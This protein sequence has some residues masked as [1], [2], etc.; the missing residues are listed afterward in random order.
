MLVSET[1]KNNKIGA[2]V[3][4][5]LAIAPILD[6]YIL[7]EIGSI[8]IR[9]MDIPML[10][11]SGYIILRKRRIGLPNKDLFML[12]VIFMLLTLITYFAP[13]DGRNLFLGMKVIIV[14]SLYAFCVSYLWKVNQYEKFIEYATNIAI[15]ATILLIIQLIA[16]SLNF[17]NFYNGKLPILQLSK[18]DGWSGLI[19]PHTGDIRVHSFFQEPS[20]FGIYCLPVFAQALKNVRLRL[21]FFLF[22]GL[23]MTSSLLSILGGVC[24]FICVLLMYKKSHRKSYNKYLLKIF[25]IMCVVVVVLIT[26]YHT[27]NSVQ[28]IINYS[29]RR[30]SSISYDL[31]GDRMG[32]TKL[33]IIGYA[34]YYKTYPTFFKIFGVGASQYPLYLTHYGV[35]TYSSTLVTILLNYGLLGLC[36]FCIWLMKIFIRSDSERKCFALIFIIICIVDCFWFNWYFFYI[37]TWFLPF[38]YINKYKYK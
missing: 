29:S 13:V 19:D 21:S 12:L 34:R 35:K 20:Y 3:A 32:S 26:L 27:N 31:L 8:T 17:L 6:P 1:T 15:I 2:M 22:L 7:F 36:V 10:L 25:F 4:F 18:Y 5:V 14:W 28:S 16:V 37:L 9:F 24:V 23:I 38:I 11:I 33:R 30:I